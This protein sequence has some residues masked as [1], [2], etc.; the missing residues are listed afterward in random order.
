[1]KNR[2]NGFTLIELLVVIAIIAILAALLLPALRNAWEMA[3]RVT[4]SGNLKQL[5]MLG[6]TYESDYGYCV[7]YQI[8]YPD[9]A[10]PS[11]IYWFTL[12]GK[13]LGWKPCGSDT[14][15]SLY[16]PGGRTYPRTRASIFM[17]PSGIWGGNKDDYFYQSTGYRNDIV[18][19]L[20]DAPTAGNRGVCLSMVRKPSAKLFL[21]D[22][23]W[24]NFYIP[25]TGKTP[26][27]TT[28]S[29]HV[30]VSPYLDDFYNGRH[31]RTINCIFLDGHLESISSDTAWYHK[32]LGSNSSASM[33][34]ILK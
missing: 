22:M 27:C 4:C 2:A 20:R 8:R 24:S 16:R 34:N 29:E 7:S 11:S 23:S 3:K 13:Q 30:Y 15:H 33:F 32:S 6:S 12:M 5:G 9:G 26:G 21:F 31:L 25:G 28:N 14:Q 17:C 1:M 18:I 10:Y 19:S